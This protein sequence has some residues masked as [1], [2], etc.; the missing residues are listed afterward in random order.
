MPETHLNDKNLLGN[1]GKHSFFEPIE[2]IEAAPGAYL[3]KTDEN[4]S[5]GNS[6]EGLIAVEDEDVPT[7]L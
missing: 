4:S 3:A 6:I 2:L 1:S 5:H 7:E